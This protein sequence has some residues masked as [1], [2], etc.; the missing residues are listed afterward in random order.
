MRTGDAPGT[1]ERSLLSNQSGDI[2]AYP[3]E[4]FQNI[5]ILDVKTVNLHPL[6]LIPFLVEH[7]FAMDACLTQYVHP[8][9]KS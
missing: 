8:V 1:E 4:C 5:C 6:E 2:R 7:A 9:A 3:F